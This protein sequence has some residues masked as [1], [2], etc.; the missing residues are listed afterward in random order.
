MNFVIPIITQTSN[1]CL[2]PEGIDKID[3]SIYMGNHQSNIH[4]TFILRSTRSAIG[5]EVEVTESSAYHAAVNIN[6]EMIELYIKNAKSLGIEFNDDAMRETLQASTDFGNVSAMKPSI[7]PDYKIKSE[8]INHN[9]KFAEAAG[10]QDSQP[11]TL[12][13]AKSMAMT[14]IDVACDK[15]LF[16]KIKDSFKKSIA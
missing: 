11:P 5:C 2:N 9:P 6:P 12:A 4:I 3:L 8:A 1:I 16:E 13:S 15:E 10:H 14:A 7:H